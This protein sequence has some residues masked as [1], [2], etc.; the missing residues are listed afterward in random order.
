[1]STSTGVS[2]RLEGAAPPPPGVRASA[3]SIRPV[4]VLLASALLTVLCAV[5]FP[6]APV[7]QPVVTFSWPQAGSGTASALPLMP[8]EPV[9]LRAEVSCAAAAS[10]PDG[11][12]V[13]ATVPTGGGPAGGLQVRRAGTSLMVTSDAVLLAV[14]GLPPGACDVVV[15]SD[16]RRTEV[17]LDGATVATDG[18]DVR[19]AVA[20][21]ATDAP[22]TTGLRVDL[23]TD[24]RFETTPSVLKIGLG[25]GCLLGLAGV[26]GAA[27]A[28]DRATRRPGGGRRSGRAPRPAP[29]DVVVGAGLVVWAV[30][31]PATVDDG[32]IAGILRGR[33]E[34]GFTGNVYRWLNA[35]EAPFSWFYELDRWWAALAPGTASVLWL[36]VPATVLGAIC[37]ALLRR[38]ALPRLGPALSRPVLGRVPAPWV[39]ALVFAAWWLP[40]GLSLR[41]EPWVAAGVLAVWV[42]TE[43]AVATAATIPL[44]VAAVLAGATVTLTPGALSGVA[45]LLVALPALLRG[46]RGRGAHPATLRPGPRIAAVVAG[47]AVAV[48]PMAADQSLGAVLEGTRVRQL[49][50]G[51][52]PWSSELE[53]YS[54]LLTVDS[55]QGSLGARLPV[56]L[57]LVALPAT[58]WA[59]DRGVPLGIARG[60]ATRLLATSALG[61]VLLVF[62]PTKWTLHFGGSGGL[63][64]AVVTLFVVCWSPRG[65][66]AL[67]RTEGPTGGGRGG[68]QAPTVVLAAV[69]LAGALVLAGDNRWPFAAD[70]GVFW[71]ADPP[72]IGGVDLADVVL[73]AGTA[74]VVALAVAA[75]LRGRPVVPA[76][77]AP[78]TVAIVLT[79]AVVVLVAGSF[80]KVTVDR[81]GTFSYGGDSVAAL[82]GDPCGMPRL[83]A[84]EPDPRA[85]LLSPVP[86]PGAPSPGP[87]PLTM[88][89]Q[90]L[91]GWVAAPLLATGWFALPDA[92]RTGEVPVVV[93][94]DRPGATVRLAF[95]DGTYGPDG[96]PATTGSA[97]P[98]GP[99]QGL[100]ARDLRAL[101]PRPATLVRVEVAGGPPG[102]VAVSVPRVPRTVPFDALVPPGSTVLADWP[103]AL[104]I[105][106]RRQPALDGGT[107]DVPPWRVVTPD[108]SDAGEIS[109]ASRTGG[110]F[111]GPRLLVEPQRIPVYLDGDPTRDAVGLERWV[112]TRPWTALTPTVG[113]E[114]VAGWTRDGRVTVPDLDTP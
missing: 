104:V 98:T 30:I 102:P 32:Y 36:R 59:L 92:A 31:G 45:P 43:R 54:E 109:V 76:A 67:Q 96:A 13:L 57:L 37:W 111:L 35:P 99:E 6:F 110:P 88:A 10:V 94:V 63:G 113:G 70:W 1:M 75:A 72:Q 53:R 15:D 71:N 74:L 21:I 66:R 56:L 100:G 2:G 112:P 106:C 73:Y 93:T 107:A 101:A 69:L 84:V 51:G 95:S 42:A 80:A 14:V 25:V 55:I 8:Y 19:P 16:P 97:T 65:V 33:G 44:V 49:I 22:T 48:V 26:A 103:V 114:T 87:V 40:F 105:G 77:L 3:R 9:T 62:S 89:G 58:T 86:G 24:T 78:A 90:A 47:L 46:A 68:A 91:P 38:H 60:P 83:L 5:A 41:P 17:R 79:A 28:A 50:G 4:R 7:S 12:A 23:R 34:N 52:Q 29:V 81:R 61:L 11:A 64:V 85:G 108:G 18:R 39:A 20:V 82:G 27:L